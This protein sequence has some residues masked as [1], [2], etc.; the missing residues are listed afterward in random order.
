MF[1]S[2]GNSVRIKSSPETINAG[3]AGKI[4]RVFGETTPSM[5]D[6]DLIGPLKEDYAL[7]VYFE[8]I[9]KSFWFDPSLLENLD[10]GAGTT[11]TLDGVEREWIKDENGQWQVS[12]LNNVGHKREPR[13]INTPKKWWKIWK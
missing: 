9:K 5:M 13:N 1:D 7:N 2:F 12:D 11:M 10:N 8:D 3:L 4:G 6:V